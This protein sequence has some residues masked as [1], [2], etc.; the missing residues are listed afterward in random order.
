M[1]PYGSDRLRIVGEKVILHSPIA[2]GWKGRSESTLMRGPHP[3][4]AVI[5]ED[6]CF[7]VLT[8]EALPLG[9]IR[10]VLI[11]WSDEHAMRFVE[12][13]DDEAEG[14][15]V[16]D[17][18]FVLSQQRKS[19]IASWSG[20]LLGHLPGAVQQR[21]AENLGVTPL[22]MTVVSCVPPMIFLGV[23]LWF[24]VGQTLGDGESPLPVWWMFV[25]APLAFESVLRFWV[26]MSQGRGVGSV[27]GTA[28]YMVWWA[29]SRKRSQMVSPFTPVEELS[30]KIIAPRAEVAFRDL[31]EMRGVLLSLLP[32]AE[33][34]R[35]AERFGFEYRKHGVGLA[36]LILFFAALGAV[37]S[38]LRYQDSGSVSSLLSLIV[39]GTLTVEQVFRLIKMERGPAGSLLAPLVRPFVRVILSRAGL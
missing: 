39:A 13:Y 16:A 14:A 8:A 11:P 24:A 20:I 1:N 38:L 10:Y 32:A 21:L 30:P 5:W 37:T 4:T 26:A 9:G 3:G 18:H 23:Y 35:L 29:I 27:I 28:L 25:A 34:V 33:Q 7:E 6:R 31:M 12:R 19:K 22:R 17:Y 36:A 15:R 2:K